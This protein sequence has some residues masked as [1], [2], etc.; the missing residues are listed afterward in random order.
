MV[1]VPVGDG[2]IR[3]ACAE[4]IGNAV[5]YAETNAFGVFDRIVHQHVCG[6]GI[7][8]ARNA[9]AQNALDAHVD[10]VWMVDS[11]VVV[12]E[13]A[14]VNLV[15]VRAAICMGWYIRGRSDEGLTCAIRHGSAGWD[16][17][18]G[19]DE[20]NAMRGED[21]PTVQVKGNGLGC[22]LVRVDTFARLPAPWF[23]FTM[24]PIGP[25][26]GE[27][28]WFCQQ[29]ANAGVP[30]FVDARVGCGHIHDRLLEAR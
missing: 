6:Y 27:D 11:D 1:S 28:Y 16:D 14:L 20:L 17:S 10:Y 15:E 25:P 29:C 22:T 8:H 19:R 12:P 21:D 26:L 23:Q 4:A 7:P 2:G 3:P 24:H 18:I 30:L 13:D 9:I 5:E